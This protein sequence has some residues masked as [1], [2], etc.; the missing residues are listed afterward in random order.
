MNGSAL[1]KPRP[2]SARTRLVSPLEMRKI[3]YGCIY[4]ICYK[5]N[6]GRYSRCIPR[7][8]IAFAAKNLRAK[9]LASVSR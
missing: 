3:K 8:E 4:K 1:G 7:R 6:G 2:K 5:A 9:V